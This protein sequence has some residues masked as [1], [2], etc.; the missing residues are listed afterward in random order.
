MVYDT[1]LKITADLL[2]R[3]C[4]EAIAALPGDP[5]SCQELW[6]ESVRSLLPTGDFVHLL[7][8]FIGSSR[9]EVE[10]N[11]DR[12]YEVMNQRSVD[13]EP[14]V[15]VADAHENGDDIDWRDEALDLLAPLSL[16]FDDD[17][18]DAI[19]KAK[20]ANP[21]N[22]KEFH[23]AITDIF[24]A[25]IARDKPCELTALK[26]HLKDTTNEIVAPKKARP[27]VSINRV[28]SGS[29]RVKASESKRASIPDPL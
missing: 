12:C 27:S 18:T 9:L 22:L 14:E 17:L 11:M 1:D 19:E 16:D 5:E 25:L 7:P 13:P 24:I 26:R 2:V 28:T 29:K 15:N 6:I 10:P 4:R 23:E 20:L 21:E 3:L 8:H